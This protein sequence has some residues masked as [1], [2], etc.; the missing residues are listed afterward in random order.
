MSGFL[1]HVLQTTDV[2]RRIN[3]NR[4]PSQW[5]LTRTHLFAPY[6]QGTFAPPEFVIRPLALPLSRAQESTHTHINN[7]ILGIWF[8]RSEH[9]TNFRS[10][11]IKLLCSMGCRHTTTHPMSG[12][13]TGVERLLSELKVRG[14][15]F[16]AG[17]IVLKK[18]L[19]KPD[20]ITS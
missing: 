13:S 20:K 4:L 11:L 8:Y 16:I 2:T 17:K 5:K 3:F 7:H 12:A 14:I 15:W 18:I 9:D 19:F 6:S 10:K 1:P